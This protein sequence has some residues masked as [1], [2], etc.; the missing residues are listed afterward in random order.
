[1]VFAFQIFTRV[2]FQRNTGITALL[3]AVVDETVFTDIEVA[4]PRV[5]MPVVGSPLRQIFIKA[6][7]ER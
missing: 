2:L 7:I 3:R 4:A 5:T 1:V 6:P